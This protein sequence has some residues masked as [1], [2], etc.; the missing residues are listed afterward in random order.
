MLFAL[1]LASASCGESR[2]R[3]IG[4][5]LPG[6]ERRFESEDRPD[7]EQA[8][9]KACGDCKVLYANAKEL[10][11]LQEA[12]GERLLKRGI[13]V[14]VIDPVEVRNGG[15]IVESARAQGVPVISYDQLVEESKPTA[16]VSFDDVRAGELQAEF[17][18]RKLREEGKPQGPIMVQNGEPAD[19]DYSLFRKGALS[20][21]KTAGVRI[22]AEHTTP[23]WEPGFSADI[24]GEMIGEIGRN[25]FVAA[26]AVTDGVA[27][28]TIEAMTRAGIDPRERPTTGAN[29]TRAGLRRIASGRQYMT[30]YKPIQPEAALAAKLAIMLANGE[31]VPSSSVTRML[32]NGTGRVRSAL[33]A[34]V[35]VT[36]GNIDSTVRA[37]R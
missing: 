24:A 37:D 11:F 10:G 6:Q 29:A 2:P 14:L 1:A 28:G 25:G 23:F 33:L 35:P 15:A 9:R 17:L 3:K 26:Y 18:V 31:E 7:F 13:D 5:L 30:I 16:Y 4:L 12:Q 27:A 21:F 36:K 8:V 19:R 22:A 32:E 34:P 20:V